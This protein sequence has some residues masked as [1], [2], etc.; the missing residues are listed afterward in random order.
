[1]IDARRYA[2]G[3]S[4]MDGHLRSLNTQAEYASWFA[5]KVSIKPLAVDLVFQTGD[6]AVVRAVVTTTDRINGQDNT[7]QVAEQFNLR[8]E[9]GV[10]RIDEVT[11]L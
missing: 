8:M 2:D 9:D 4:L 1:L 5:N 6:Q 11:R 3:Y 7:T 10:W